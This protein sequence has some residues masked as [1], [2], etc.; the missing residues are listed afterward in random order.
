MN[1][2]RI[3]SLFEDHDGNIWIG[4]IT[5]LD[6]YNR[7][8]KSLNHFSHNNFNS[9]SLKSNWINTVFQSKDGSI[10]IGTMEGGLN[11]LVVR[12]GKIEFEH[13]T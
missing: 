8:D 11:K 10:W 7:K 6:R 4:T 5:G 13:A 9:S 1:G 12:K 3:N 2:M